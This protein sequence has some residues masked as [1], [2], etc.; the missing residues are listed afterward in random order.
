[1]AN[2]KLPIM[3]GN[4]LSHLPVVRQIRLGRLLKELWRSTFQLVPLRNLGLIKSTPADEDA[5]TESIILIMLLGSVKIE[6]SR[7]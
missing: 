5:F 1:M 7:A 3:Q 4:P 2:V 6:N